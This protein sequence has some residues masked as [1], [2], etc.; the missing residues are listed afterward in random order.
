MLIWKGSGIFIVADDT[1]TELNLDFS[2][3]FIPTT[4]KNRQLYAAS[5]LS[6]RRPEIPFEKNTIYLSA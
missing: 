5:A 3:Q 6:P 4:K 2:T 1:W